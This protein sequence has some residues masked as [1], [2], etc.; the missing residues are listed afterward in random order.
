VFLRSSEEYQASDVREAGPAS[1]AT[2]IVARVGIWYRGT[3][4][5]RV[6]FP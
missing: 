1:N 6:P 4:I 2:L 3:G 5:S